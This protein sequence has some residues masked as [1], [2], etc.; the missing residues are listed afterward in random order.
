[1]IGHQPAQQAAAD[2]VALETEIARV[3]KDK[4]ARRDPRGNYHKI[5]RAG[6]ARAMPRLDWDAYW[7]ALGLKDVKDVTVNSVELLSG[8]DKLLASTPPEVWR[9]YLA[10][11]VADDAAPLLTKQLEDIQFKFTSAVTGQPEQ[12]PRWKRCVSHTVEA[13]GDLVGQLFVRDRFG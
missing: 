9:A 8:L 11:H 10:F 4:V 13:L 5:D 7:A 6:V 1:A 3:S 2:I 12:S